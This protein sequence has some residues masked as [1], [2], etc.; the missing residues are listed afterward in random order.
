MSKFYLLIISFL[1]LTSVGFTQIT[2]ENNIKTE[3]TNSGIMETR[4]IFKRNGTLYFTWGYNRGFFS[5][6]D[7]HFTGD[8]YNFTITD[9]TARDDQ[10]KHDLITYFK[11][12]T[13]TIPQFNW[14]F[15]YYISDKTFFTLGLDH[16][17]YAIDKQSTLLTG[18]ITSGKKMGTYNEAEVLVGED[19]HSGV[20]QMALL[21]SLPGGFVEEFEHCDGLNDLGIEMGHLEQFWISKNGKHSISMNGTF[22]FGMVIPDSDTDVLGHKPKHDMEAG[23]KSYHLSGYSISASFG[24]QVD[25]F[26]HFF[27]LGKLKAGYMNLPDITTTVEGGRAEQ[28]FN[29]IEPL[30]VVG[31]SHLIFNKRK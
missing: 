10:D 3:N 17:K 20:H 26:T 12:N 15:G 23:K 24:L 2:L 31:Y 28:H 5:H 7:I 19:A 8:E 22:G 13:F 1:V 30:L 14:R 29:F 16:M 6:S 18:T 4:Q 25:F 27:V 11:P 9:L 21:D